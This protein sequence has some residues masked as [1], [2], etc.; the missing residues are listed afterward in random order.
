MFRFHRTP[1]RCAIRLSAL[2]ALSAAGTLHAQVASFDCAK[3]SSPT[4]RAICTSPVL[5]RKDVV[6]AT[7]VQVLRQLKPAQAGMAYR[8]FDDHL[9]VEQLQWLQQARNVCAGN[10]ACLNRSYDQR[11]ES[12]QKTLSANAALTFGRNGE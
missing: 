2:L 11:I 3:A 7:Y 4:E 9:R 6:M 10:V 12:L 5:G 1:S 8:E